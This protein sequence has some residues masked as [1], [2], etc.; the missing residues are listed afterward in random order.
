MS[1]GLDPELEAAARGVLTAF[2]SRGWRLALAESCTGGLAAA[3]LTA[4]PGSSRVVEAGVVSYSNAAKTRLLGVEPALIAAHGAV[5]EPVAVAMAEGVRARMAVEAAASITGIAG[6]G[7]SEFKP[8]GRVCFGLARTEKP[9]RAWT[10]DFGALG[11]GEVRRRAALE[12]LGALERAAQE[13]G[14]PSS[15]RGA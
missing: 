3:A 5:S 1:A 12:A 11:R 15:E 10:V 14:P 8:E 2:E 4:V 7:G 13:Q 9:T 6:P